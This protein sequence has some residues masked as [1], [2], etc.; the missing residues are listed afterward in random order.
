MKKHKG[1]T[2]DGKRW[3]PT[4]QD[5]SWIICAV[6]QRKN[7]LR[8][9][10][11]ARFAD[12]KDR[13]RRQPWLAASEAVWEALVSSVAVVGDDG[14]ICRHADF[15]DSAGCICVR[16]RGIDLY[17]GC[18][19]TRYPQRRPV[20]AAPVV[21]HLPDGFHLGKSQRYEEKAVKT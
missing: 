6:R 9:H 2:V 3:I 17:G 10:L 1:I 21:Y 7:A 19:C 5:W 18:D 16:A 4:I 12:R 15:G 14:R 11:S 8:P 13:K 20:H